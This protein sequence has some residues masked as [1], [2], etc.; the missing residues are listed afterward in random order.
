MMATATLGGSAEAIW[1]A[2]VPTLPGFTVEVVPQIDSTNTELMRRA[3]SAPLDPVL[4]VAEQQTAGRGRLGRGWHSQAGQ[5]LTFSLGLM[6]APREW[7]VVTPDA[8]AVADFGKNL[9]DP[10]KRADAARAGLRQAQGL[11]TEMRHVWSG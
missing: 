4:L 6:L 5:S 2:V 1:Q 11:V 9:L 8:D 10:A 3:R 7:S